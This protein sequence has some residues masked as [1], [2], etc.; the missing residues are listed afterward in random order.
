MDHER[1]F[2]RIKTG[3]QAVLIG[4][5]HEVTGDLVDI[6]LKGALIELENER[7][8]H[9]GDYTVRIHLPDSDV[10]MTFYGECVHEEGK[11]YG[12]KF[13]KEDIESITHLRRY[14]ELNCADYDKITGELAFLIH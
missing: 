1:H 12:I 14:L 10:T 4:Q 13:L 11:H 9:G 6:C 7:C 2:T 5:G 3:L 8:I